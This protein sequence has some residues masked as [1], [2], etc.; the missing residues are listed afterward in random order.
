MAFNFQTTQ[1]AQ[2]TAVQP[3]V[4]QPITPAPA[5]PA[6]GGFSA[7]IFSGIENAKPVVSAVYCGVGRYVSQIIRCFYKVTQK[8]EQATIVEMRI[9]CVLDDA[10]GQGHRVGDDV[11][12]FL[13]VSNLYFPS[14]IRGFVSGTI[15]APFEQ[16]SEQICTR[17]FSDENPLS[18]AFVEWRGTQRPTQAGGLFTNIKFLR[19]VSAAEVK[20][21]MPAEHIAAMYPNGALDLLIQKEQQ[22][23]A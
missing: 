7:G 16:V 4:Q 15:G 3:Q 5:T 23:T 6:A 21:L 19:P 11:S 22:P 10:A 18:G 14:E 8:R 9:V 13:K 1:Q 20:T 17:V 2:T 12:W